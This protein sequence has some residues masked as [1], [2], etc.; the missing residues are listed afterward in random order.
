MTPF[1][2]VALLAA[3]ALSRSV[4]LLSLGE[5]VAKG[6]GVN[7]LVV[8]LLCS[9]VVLV[10][11]GASVSV[12]GSV[13]FVGLVIPHLARF[14]TGMDYRWIIPSSAVLGA[15]L[16]VLAD[17]GAR[18]LNPPFETPLGALIALI[19]VPFFLYLARKQKRAL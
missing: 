11:A 18:T 9:V 19:G 8:N 13:G 12:V 6:L 15:L 7:T 3:F 10:L 4:S 2:A 16:V 14:I 1:I 5:D 17:L